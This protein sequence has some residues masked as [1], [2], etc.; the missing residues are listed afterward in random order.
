MLKKIGL[1]M[2]VFVVIIGSVCWAAPASTVQA[3]QAYQE[4]RK[5]LAWLT[6][7]LNDLGRSSD[8]KLKL[9]ADQKKKILPVFETLISNNLVLLTIPEHERRNSQSAGSRT[10]F[11]ANDPKVQARIRKMKDQTEL[12]NQQADLVDGFLTE[13][14]LSYIDNLEFNAEKYGFIDFQKLFGGDQRQR[15]D[16]KTIAEMR[17]KTRAGQELLVKLNNEVLKM[18][19]S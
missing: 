1:L 13:K 6:Q 5:N 10:Q 16:Q 9:T 11:N 18:L 4:M 2:M 12:G 19:K 8:G 7:G 17:A 3:G 14:Q 15:P